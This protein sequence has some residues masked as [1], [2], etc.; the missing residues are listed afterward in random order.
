MTG[1]GA[2]KPKAKGV[3]STYKNKT[4]AL[5]GTI[6][7][8]SGD[9]ARYSDFAVSLCHVACPQGTRI[10]WVKSID[11]VGSANQIVESTVGDWLW[12][13]GDDHV[14]EPDILTR[15]LSHNVDVVV[16]LCLQ[17]HPPFAPVVYKGQ[18]MVEGS[19][20]HAVYDNLPE[21]GLVE[22]HAAGNAGMLIKKY[23]L[24]AIEPPW[25]GT[26]GEGLNEDLYFCRR[27]R[28]AGFKIHCD[29]ET[30]LGHMNVYCIWPKL[31]EHGWGVGLQLDQKNVVTINRA[32]GAPPVEV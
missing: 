21:T 15:L 31:N 13:M 2:Y 4:V 20:K 14:F 22:V 18:A 11:I 8:Q 26:D 29:V 32:P 30:F 27:V 1:V 28:E 7:V 23:V 10:R 19:I 9:L 24:D 6:G 5:P 25:F 12:L 16:P 17:R 3:P